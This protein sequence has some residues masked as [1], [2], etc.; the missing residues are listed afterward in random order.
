MSDLDR[1]A[2]APISFNKRLNV[3][4]V[5]IVSLLLLFF[6]KKKING[7][8]KMRLVLLCFF[9]FFFFWLD[10]AVM[11]GNLAGEYLLLIEAL[12]RKCSGIKICLPCAFACIECLSRFYKKFVQF[13]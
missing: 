1:A 6:F 12:W 9:F 8:L 11:F 10:D 4:H 5:I 2:S 7:D 3:K 13:N